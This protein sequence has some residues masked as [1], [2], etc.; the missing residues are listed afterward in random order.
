MTH[1]KKIFKE[2]L[3]KFLINYINENQHTNIKDIILQFLDDNYVINKSL[4]I[5]FIVHII[6]KNNMINKY[7][8]NESDSIVDYDLLLNNICLDIFNDQEFFEEEDDKK[9]IIIDKIIADYEMNID[10]YQNII[11]ERLSAIESGTKSTD[12][13]ENIQL[14]DDENE[15]HNS[16]FI[17]TYRFPLISYIKT[18]F[19]NS[20]SDII[21]LCIYI[22]I[23]FGVGYYYYNKNYIDENL[24]KNISKNIKISKMSVGLI[25]INIVICFLSISSLVDK[26]YKIMPWWFYTLIPSYRFRTLH[27][28]SGIVFFCAIIIHIVTHTINIFIL[29]DNINLC[30]FTVL[31][32]KKLGFKTNIFYENYDILLTYPFISGFIVLLFAIIHFYYVLR[33][34]NKNIIISAFKLKSIRHSLFL[35]NHWKISLITIT[36]LLFHGLKQ[37]L[38]I[39]TNW[40][41]TIWF[42]I[43]YFIENRY[44]IFGMNKSTIIYIKNY[45]DKLLE[46]TVNRPKYIKENT[47]GMSCLLNIPIIHK[48]EWH[49]FTIDYTTDSIIFFIEVVGQW[50]NN[51]KQLSYADEDGYIEL[52]NKEIYLSRCYNNI[53]T[54]A[55]NYNISI[56][57]VFGICITTLISFLKNIKNGT[58]LSSV[59]KKIFII[60]TLNDINILYIFKDLINEIIHDQEHKISFHIFITQKMSEF[61]NLLLTY[62]QYRSLLINGEDVLSGI[63][64]NKIYF[65]R[66]DLTNILK[67]IIRYSNDNNYYKRI[68]IFLCGSPMMQKKMKNICNKHNYNIYNYELQFHKVQ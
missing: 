52:Y 24:F 49:P 64:N 1:F 37:W 66:P 9:N 7:N 11:P 59:T 54:Y 12:E 39:T 34:N 26:L 68:G 3:I 51:L 41:W 35:N 43:F 53:I 23:N 27:F 38:S 45:Q 2:E 33:L 42:I 10:S 50:S 16:F 4:L 32:L 31:N 57:Y 62:I 8:S 13:I 18:W 28:I 22:S 21:L 30:T 6:K 20:I 15:F 61:D 58:N 48:N 63:K 44:R 5:M 19:I 56:I 14:I 25:N 17:S 46:L 40:I 65:R 29:N 47:I 60:W 36:L 55:N 67:N